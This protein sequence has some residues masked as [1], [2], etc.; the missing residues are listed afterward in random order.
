MIRGDTVICGTSTT[1]TGTLTLAATPVPPGGVDFNAFLKATGIGFASGNAILVSYTII[2]YTDST[3]ATAKSHEK[4]VGTLTLGAAI[5]NATLARSTVQSTATSLNSQP[6]TQN[7]TPG[8]GISIGTA[9]NTLVFIGPSASDTLAATP[10]FD[11]GNST[12]GTLPFGTYNISSAYAAQAQNGACYYVP[13]YWVVPMLTKRFTTTTGS[14]G[15]TGGT[16]NA[17][18]ALYA[19]G[20]DGQPGKRLIDYGV[21]GT[22]NSSLASTFTPITSASH[23]SG[24]FITPGFYYAAIFIAISGGSGAPNFMSFN[25]ASGDVKGTLGNVILGTNGVNGIY[26]YA[27]ATATANPAPDPATKTGFFSFVSSGG[28]PNSPFFM[29]GA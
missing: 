10:Y 29:L 28:A 19:V 22:A 11:S 5:V 25:G 8:T 9:A 16:S 21:L 13:F 20:T 14:T 3:F 24:F 18:A 27:T 26:T 12:L 2:E 17:Y 6:A 1:G 15:Y 7:I 4:G 23:A